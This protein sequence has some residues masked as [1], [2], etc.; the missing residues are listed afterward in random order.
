MT[1]FRILGVV[2]VAGLT[3]GVLAGCVAKT[4]AAASDTFAVSASDTACDVS[5]ATATSGTVA[6]EVTN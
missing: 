6:F 2:G 1:P 4:P 3:I 5:A